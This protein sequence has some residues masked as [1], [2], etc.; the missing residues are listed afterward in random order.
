MN[1]K[2]VIFKQSKWA[3][4]TPIKE[5]ASSIEAEN[6][7]LETFKKS[8]SK[9]TLLKETFVEF[10]CRTDVAAYNKIFEY[11]NYFAK[12]TWFSLFH[13]L[14]FGHECIGLFRM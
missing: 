4:V 1:G 8:K 11:E 5:I 7:S 2:K 10:S 3:K 13:G 9:W 12:V 6:K 14:L